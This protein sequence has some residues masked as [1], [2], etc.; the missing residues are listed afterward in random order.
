MPTA[1]ATIPRYAEHLISRSRWGVVQLLAVPTVLTLASLLW[2]H[3]PVINTGTPATTMAVAAATAGRVA[4]SAPPTVAPAIEADYRQAL[5]LF[6]SSR[7]AAAYGRF[8]QLADAGHVP[9]A[10]MALVMVEQGPRHFGS[11][12]DAWPH[13]LRDWAGLAREPVPVT[14]ARAATE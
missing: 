7:Y 10:R 13:Q 1:L 5:R 4:E 2:P 3:D 14:M 6:R 8:A 12:W 11:T 9:S